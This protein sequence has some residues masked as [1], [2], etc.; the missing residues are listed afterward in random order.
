MRQIQEFQADFESALEPTFIHLV[1][2]ACSFYRSHTGEI[3]TL[4]TSAHFFFF[5][6]VL[7]SH[8]YALYVC[9]T[10]I[11]LNL[12]INPVQPLYWLCVPCD[13]RH[14]WVLEDT[15]NATVTPCNCFF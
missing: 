3:V 5:I 13:P 14:A 7:F 12:K 10:K 1:T 4:L 15:L 2:Y 6:W 11:I 8:K 9:C